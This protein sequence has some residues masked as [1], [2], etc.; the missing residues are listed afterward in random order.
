MIKAK[1]HRHNKSNTTDILMGA[2]NFACVGC[3][4]IIKKYASG[5]SVICERS[6]H[7]AS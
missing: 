2:A 7:T 4:D 3:M 5:A 1:Q 6:E